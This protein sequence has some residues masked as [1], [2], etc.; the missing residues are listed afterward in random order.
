MK[1]E[2]KMK[3]LTD[4]IV[5]NRNR[6]FCLASRLCFLPVL[7]GLFAVVAL[8]TSAKADIEV[9]QSERQVDASAAATFEGVDY[10]LSEPYVG[11]SDPDPLGDNQTMLLA[12]PS[13]GP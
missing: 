7:L 4:R 5:S 8:P 9:I 1:T 2:T 10:R 12:N 11:G 3:N 6:Q 13:L